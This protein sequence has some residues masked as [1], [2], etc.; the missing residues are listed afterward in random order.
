MFFVRFCALLGH[1]KNI[2]SIQYLLRLRHIGRF[3]QKR[4]IIISMHFSGYIFREGWRHP[5]FI[6]VG[7]IL[8]PF[9][10][11]FGTQNRKKDQPKNIKTKYSKKGMLVCAGTW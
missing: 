6:D 8:G 5:F 10:N 4:K 11:H 7:S 9:L 3:E 2:V 1:A